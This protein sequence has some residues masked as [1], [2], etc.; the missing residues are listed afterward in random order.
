MP[1]WANNNIDFVMKLRQI[2]ESD[3]VSNN[4]HLWI[5]SIFGVNQKSIKIQNTN[6]EVKLF[7]QTA[8]ENGVDIGNEPDEYK[9]FLYALVLVGLIPNQV[10]TKPFPKRKENV[11]SKN[12]L[13]N[14]K[15]QILSAKNSNTSNL[16]YIGTEPNLNKNEN[17]YIILKLILNNIYLV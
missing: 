5:D 9:E 13:D 7:L 17:V 2:F 10:Y 14:S 1:E 15:L 6:I 4:L 8:Y 16:G 12:L 11:A 3:K